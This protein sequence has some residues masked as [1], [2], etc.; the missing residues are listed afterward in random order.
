MQAQGLTRRWGQR[1][2]G[3][4]DAE[5]TDCNLLSIDVSAPPQPA[6]GE[7][8]EGAGGGGAGGGGAR[9]LDHLPD[10]AGRQ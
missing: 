4:P 10:G 1:I 6:G 8:G 7:A 3:G 5:L 2:R 9:V